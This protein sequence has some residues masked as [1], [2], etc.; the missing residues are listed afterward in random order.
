MSVRHSTARLRR[1]ALF[2]KQ[3]PYTA[4]V[5]EHVVRTRF[6]HY[7]QVLKLS[8]A[9]F[10]SADDAEINA[11]HERLN[12]LWRNLASANVALWIHLV[13]HREQSYPEGSFPNP[14]AAALNARYRQRIAGERLMVNE[15]Y[16]SLVH[17]PTS[18]AV[19]GLASKLLTRGRQVPDRFAL[20]E[21][22][23]LYAR[24]A[25]VYSHVLEFLSLLIN[26]EGRAVPLTGAPLNEFL[27][28]ARPSFGMETLEYRSPTA[29][30]LGAMLGIKE[31]ATP[32][33]P[34]LFNSL[35]SAPFPL[36]LTQSFTFL[37]KGTSQALLVR[38]YNRMLNSGDFAHSQAEE[39]KDA[40]DALTSGEFV[41]GDHHLDRKS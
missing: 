3:I 13:R 37:S 12:V 25:H 10:E 35:L 40:L 18:G 23:G 30:R 28:L 20:P 6:G 27:G 5:S 26:G 11:W 32:T 2:A 31:Y 19:T 21:A 8:G 1:E 9:S 33:M 38:Q 29:T 36:I 41:M 34:G 4:Q 14:F 22:L 7:V 16:L 24:G 15:W 17:R 39:L